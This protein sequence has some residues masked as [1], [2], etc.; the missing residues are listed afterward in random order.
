MTPRG[1]AS[2]VLGLLACA[3]A[4]GPNF[5]R[6]PAPSAA[7]YAMQGDD[8]A[9]AAIRLTPSASLPANWW[10]SFNN[11]DLDAL[12]AQA[13]ANSPTL[14]EADANL[15]VA[16]ADAAATRGGQ[17]PQINGAASAVRER[18][19]TQA[20]GFTGFPSPTIKLYSVGAAVSFDLDIFGGRRRA[21]ERD[22]A[23]AAAEQARVDAA[24]LT[25]SGNVVREAVL[26]AGL[27]AKVA[28]QD[29][30]V[31]GD[32]SI[33]DMVGRAIQAGGQPSAAADTVQAQLAEDESAGPALR[34]Q[35]TEARHRLALLV[36]RAPADWSAP[37]LDL[38]GFTPPA[39]I[40]VSVPSEL[41]RRRPDILA[42]EADLHAATANIG[43]QTASLYPNLAI[44][45]SLTQS[46]IDPSDI[47]KS[48]SAGW[49]IGPSLTAPLFHGGAL[50]AQVRAANAEQRA[51]LAIYQQTVL[52]AFV[53]VADAI[54]A[55]GNDQQSVDIQA[56]AVAAA[57]ANVRNT[58]LA[59]ENGAAAL[60][61]LVDAQRQ[62][63]RARLAAVDA[64]VA[65]YQD[66]AALY[67]ATAADWRKPAQ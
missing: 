47:F 54:E 17:L 12:V 48:A 4:V 64:R 33:L 11:A 26:I 15:R 28:A 58:R 23:H 14:A 44:N 9:A 41:V 6:P 36:G 56:R 38:A 22:E 31:A 46:A 29:E 51:K 27:R 7:G 34:Q 35:L 50:H 59:Y 53:Q 43:V 65:L 3:C 8:P 45:P 13:L 39:E 60:L 52:V 21:V 2:P 55:V 18:I 61:T 10:S 67:V 37:D 62:A 5:E 66:I 57:D 49:S 25:L 32:H 20:F 16:Q 40:P 30:I 42:A 1:L 24:Y 63:N 19:N